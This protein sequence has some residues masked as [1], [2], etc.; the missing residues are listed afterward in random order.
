MKTLRRIAFRLCICLT[1]SF[2]TFRCVAS[3]GDWSWT[4][5]DPQPTGASL[6]DVACNGSNCVAVGE[7]GIIL[8]SSNGGVNWTTVYSPVLTDLEGVIPWQGNFLA[9]GTGDVILRIQP[10]STISTTSLFGQALQVNDMV[11]ISNTLVVAAFDSV[12]QRTLLLVS[13]DAQA[14]TTNFIFNNFNGSLL[15]TNNGV[16]LLS[17]NAVSSGQS[18]ILRSTNLVNWDTIAFN[19]GNTLQNPSTRLCSAGDYFFDFPFLGD[20]FYKSSNGLD[21]ASNSV[22]TN[23][24]NTQFAK[25]IKDQTTYHFIGSYVEMLS[26]SYGEFRTILMTTDFT[27]W[28]T[29]GTVGD[30]QNLTGISKSSTFLVTVGYAGTMLTA[31]LGTTNWSELNSVWQGRNNGFFDYMSYRV[32]TFSNLVLIL[33]GQNCLY[34]SNGI[35]W[36]TNTLPTTFYGICAGN[37]RIVARDS[38]YPVNAWITT[39]GFNWQMSAGLGNIFSDGFIFGG[40]LFVANQPNAAPIAPFLTSSNGI[41]WVAI[42][43]TTQLSL[44]NFQNGNWFATSNYTVSSL[45]G[46]TNYS[47]VYTSQNLSNWTASGLTF[48]W[49]VNDVY[50]WKNQYYFIGHSAGNYGQGVLYASTN[51]NTPNAVFLTSSGISQLLSIGNTLL[52]TVGDGTI[53]YS[54]NGVNWSL[55]DIYL[56]E[57]GKISQFANRLILSAGN[58]IISSSP[59]NSGIRM[60][61]LNNTNYSLDVWGVPGSPFSVSRSSNLQTWAGLSNATFTGFQPIQIGTVQTTN[62]AKF[63]KINSSP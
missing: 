24:S 62:A 49:G 30:A 56:P 29:A 45:S 40:G 51:F 13:T 6:N 42:S 50:W 27:N 41:N 53:W 34:S 59:F 19:P 10:P 3:T 20:Y 33:D 55:S 28:T 11:V 4:W 58:G 14:W 54:T 26:S 2:L 60:R 44:L 46:Y 1:F 47:A 17:G 35:Q 38:Q 8:M 32:A 48:P 23:F 36:F 37:G 31:P 57:L 43:N 63:F 15:A 16:T 22:P 7:N 5:L 25:V 39:N 61:S 18:S 9:W 12:N 52:A 21:W